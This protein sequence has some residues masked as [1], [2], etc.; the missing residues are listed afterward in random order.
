MGSK[1]SRL[2]AANNQAMRQIAVFMVTSSELVN[3][4]G[5]QDKI[6]VF[7]FN[8]KPE[9]FKYFFNFLRAGIADIANIKNDGS[10]LYFII[11]SADSEFSKKMG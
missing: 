8:I 1:A 7:I 3:F 6:F 11:G 2:G 4:I 5:N 9:L 10:L